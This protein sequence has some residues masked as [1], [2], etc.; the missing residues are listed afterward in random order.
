MTNS[1]NNNYK[2]CAS[3]LDC[4]FLHLSDEIDKAINIGVDMFHL[5]VMDGQFVPNISLGQ[6][7][8]K[9]IRSYTDTPLD[10]HLMVEKPSSNL[11]S[12]IEC[13]PDFLCVHAEECTHLSYDLNKIKKADIKAAV[14]LNPATPISAIENVLPYLDMVLIMTVNPGFGG[15]KLLPECLPKIKKLASM[16]RNYVESTKDGKTI[17]IQVDGGINPQT[18]GEVIAA[19]AN[20]LVLGSAIFKAENP[21]DVIKKVRELFKNNK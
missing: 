13:R 20:I 21:S 1:T 9:L 6:P 4:D 17:D 10:V 16:I 3:I 8:I 19:G 2:I 7:I 12:F 5:D 11:D 14:A 15:Q 18:A